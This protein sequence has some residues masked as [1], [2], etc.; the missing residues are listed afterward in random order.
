MNKKT[1]K[2]LSNVLYLNLKL[3]QLKVSTASVCLYCNQ[4][5]E[6]VTSFQQ[7]QKSYFFIMAKIKLYFAN[8]IKLIA[9]CPQISILGH[10]NTD[11]RCFIAE[12][13][14]LL[15]CKFCVYKSR[16]RGHLSFTAFS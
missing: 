16:G 6:T 10:T 9:L 2:I 4:H 1:Q 15:I 5:D 14:I 13:L 12:N 8:N 11:Y 3:F 7:V